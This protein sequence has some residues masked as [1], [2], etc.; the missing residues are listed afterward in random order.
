MPVVVKCQI[1]GNED[2]VKPSYAKRYL[3]CSMECKKQYLSRKYSGENN[4]NYRGE[5]Y[6]RIKRIS[7]YGYVLVYKPESRMARCDGYVLEH[8]LVM[9]EHLGRDLL[10]DEHVH[11]KDGDRTN[12][13][14][15]NLEITTLAEHSKH[16]SKEKEIIRD[17]RGRI[18]DVITKK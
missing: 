16:H 18:V 9:G 1:C 8:R 17:K 14:I 5:N 11:H 2:K 4:P 7:N 12:N 3:T 10:P 15:N 13:D 6:D